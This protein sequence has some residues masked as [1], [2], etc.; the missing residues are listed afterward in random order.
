MQRVQK[1]CER[2]WGWFVGQRLRCDN[3]CFCPLKHTSGTLLKR[4]SWADLRLRFAGGRKE[5]HKPQ[6]ARHTQFP[7]GKNERSIAA[8]LWIPELGLRASHIA[9]RAFLLPRYPRSNLSAVGVDRKPW[10]GEFMTQDSLKWIAAGCQTIHNRGL[11]P[12]HRHMTGRL[13]G[14]S[15][16]GK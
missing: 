14:R 5:T 8:F 13:K 12:R 10:L 7:K 11:K 16:S 3:I 9:T 4:S 2:L 1:V 15:R 6:R